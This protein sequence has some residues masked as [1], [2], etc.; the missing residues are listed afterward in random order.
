[1]TNKTIDD[2]VFDRDLPLKKGLE[3]PP[4]FRAKVFFK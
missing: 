2:N 4:K 1:L 3:N